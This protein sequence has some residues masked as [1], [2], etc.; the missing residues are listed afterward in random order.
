VSADDPA[1]VAFTSGSTGEPKGVLGR[2]GPITHFLPW[3]NEAFDL[4]NSDRFCLLSGLGYNHLQRDVFTALA[5]G[6]TL[7]IPTPNLLKSPDRLIEWLEHQEITI[8]HLTPALGRLLVT[9]AGKTLPSLRRIFFG[10]DLLTSHDVS[11]VRE[12][13]PNAQIVSFYG[14]TET[15][16][17]VGYFEISEDNSNRLNQ[18]NRPIP[19]GRGT[20]DVQL[21]LLTAGGELAGIGELGELYVR[22]PHLAHGYMADDALTADNFIKNP[23]TNDPGDRLYRTGDMG[24]YLPDGNVEWVGRR[25]RRV[26]IRG[27]RVE[28]AEIEAT[29]NQHGAVT[30]SAVIGRELIKA[31]EPTELR[32]VAYVEAQRDRPASVEELRCFLNA[33]LPSYMVPAQIV[34]VNHLPLNPNGKVDFFKLPE[35]PPL[36]SASELGLAGPPTSIE[37]TLVE[38]FSDVLGLE[39]IGPQENFFHL[40]GH[41]LLAAQV[42]TRLKETLKVALDL[43]MFFETPTVEGL[44]RQVEVLQAVAETTQGAQ[45]IGREQIE[46]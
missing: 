17:A 30:N 18:S 22:S 33:K 10:G 43:R 34:I 13:A 26:S 24:R 21:L 19:L 42:V 44:A 1:Y 46:I 8:L 27:F 25:D 41:S 37:Q 40:G 3:Q 31:G 39:R 28:L 4:R 6:A 35:P 7:Y 16:R 23:F 15:Q 45:D 20:K 36:S 12:L 32:L 9:A 5:L 11:S 38:I 29:L 2:H 14:A